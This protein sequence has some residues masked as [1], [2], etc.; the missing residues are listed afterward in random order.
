MNENGNADTLIGNEDSAV[1]TFRDSMVFLKHNMLRCCPRR[2]L[3]APFVI[4]LKQ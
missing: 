3:F 4:D 1:I 2:T